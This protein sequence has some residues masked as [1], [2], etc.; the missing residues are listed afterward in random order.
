MNQQVV[1]RSS[2]TAYQVVIRPHTDI[3]NPAP[4]L[5]AALAGQF[6]RAETFAEGRLC[7]SVPGSTRGDDTR[8]AVTTALHAAAAHQ[9][10][11]AGTAVTVEVTD[12]RYTDDGYCHVFAQCATSGESGPPRQSS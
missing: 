10:T 9:E 3:R 1:D 6:A 2:V 8:T 12:V 7:L 4:A 5:V 11:S